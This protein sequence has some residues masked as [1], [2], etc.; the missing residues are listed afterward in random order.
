MTRG[1][2][3]VEWAK[4]AL[5]LLL[6]A[7]ALVLAWRTELFSAYINSIPFFGSVA[8]LVKGTTGTTEI[9]SV[10][11]KEA[12]RPLSIVITNED[13]RRYGAKYDTD[14]RNAVYERTSSILCEAL[15]SASAPE[16]I[17]EEEWREALSGPG[18]FF[19]Y[20]NPV[21]LSILDGW[22]GAHM[23]ETAE[24]ISLRY[25]Y[26]A[27]GEDKSRI[28]YQDI[29]RGLFFGADTASAA[30]KVQELD[31]YSENGAMFA[32]ETVVS[33]ENNAPYML[34]MPE[35]DH[36]DIN[37]AAA[38]SVEEL[39]DIVITAM[40]HSEETNTTYPDSRGFFVCVGTQFNIRVDSTGRILYRRTDALPISIERQMP[41]PN[42]IIERARVI[43]AET[44]SKTCGDAEV[45]FESMEY[46]PDG[47]CSVYFGYY[48]AGGRMFLR[49]D[50][51]AARISFSPGMVP[52]IEVIFRNFTLTDEYTRLLPERQAFAA[53][54]GEFLLCYSDA[55][56]DI[57]QPSWARTV[58]N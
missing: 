15:G 17:S 58:D 31:I 2:K 20:F 44:I 26:I 4:T 16:E 21:R 23:P 24:D 1:K 52:E 53:A 5:I 13:G 29:E 50:N 47:S 11:L 42:E 32:F 54:G 28:Y 37:A 39:L 41:N 14:I 57:L 25:V 6:S 8:D 18:V 22:L 49:D 27:F 10:E 36:P 30:G 7:S 55:G 43:V 19:E 45:F 56:L 33:D 51:H 48:V 12:A 9:S 40:G 46:Y 34:I 38:G 3:A 35:S